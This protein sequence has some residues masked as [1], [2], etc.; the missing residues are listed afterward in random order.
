MQFTDAQKIYWMHGCPSLR[1]IHVHALHGANSWSV[2]KFPCFL[3]NQIAGILRPIC[4]TINVYPS[5]NLV[6]TLECNKECNQN[7]PEHNP[8][9]S[10][11][12]AD[13]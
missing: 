13:P 3:A 2:K 6:V 11:L 10:V 7:V 5:K 8:G 4:I 1:I 9:L 12:R